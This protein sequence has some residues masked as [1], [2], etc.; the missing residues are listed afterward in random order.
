MIRICAWCGKILGEKEPLEDRSET[1]GMC[2]GCLEKLKAENQKP[3]EAKP[4]RS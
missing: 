2:D 1:H 3:T 4:V